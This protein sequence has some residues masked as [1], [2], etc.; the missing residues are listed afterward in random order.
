MKN[1][2]KIEKGKRIA[3]SFAEST[4]R[5][6][7]SNMHKL[8]NEASESKEMAKSFFSLLS[9]KLDLEH[10]TTAPTEEEVKEAVEQLKDIGRLSVFSTAVI[11]PGGVFSLL[12]LELLAR[13]FGVKNFTFVP[14]A[15]RKNAEWKYPKGAKVP[16]KVFYPEKKSVSDITPALEDEEQE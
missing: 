2:F 11:L 5:V 10:R 4:K 7:D 13:K 1:I 12:G 3:K 9:H 15:F 16:E 6:L 8:G 14:S